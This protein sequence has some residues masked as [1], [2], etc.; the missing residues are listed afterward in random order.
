VNVNDPSLVALVMTWTTPVAALL[1]EGATPFRFLLKLVPGCERV[2]FVSI[3]WNKI[4]DASFIILV[5]MRLDDDDDEDDDEDDDDEADDDDALVKVLMIGSAV[6]VDV[7]VVAAAS[8]ADGG[9]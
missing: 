3:S 2:W 9:I 6:A 5:W 4:V 7:V 1:K 8:V